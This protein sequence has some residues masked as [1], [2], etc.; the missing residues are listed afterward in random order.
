MHRFPC[1]DRE[2]IPK[3]ERLPND[4]QS[5]PRRDRHRRPGLDGLQ[6]G[7]GRPILEG[8]GDNPRS[9]SLEDTRRVKCAA[10]EVLACFEGREA[11][12]LLLAAIRDGDLAVSRKAHELLNQRDRARTHRHP[13]AAPRERAR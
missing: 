13:A 9:C 5:D 4:A 3:P 6:P 10:L 11:N 7:L 2:P 12:Q 1:S 8:P